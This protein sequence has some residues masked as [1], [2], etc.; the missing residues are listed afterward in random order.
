MGSVQS[1]KNLSVKRSLRVSVLTDA[2]I[3]SLQFSNVFRAISL[4]KSKY[5]SSGVK[6]GHG[7]QE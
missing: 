6:E 2:L 1:V 3:E 7:Y 4:L 5:I